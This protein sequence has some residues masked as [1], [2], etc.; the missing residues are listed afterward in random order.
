MP[1]KG[2][3][4]E[5][6]KH[7]RQTIGVA[8]STR[9]RYS[10]YVQHF[11]SETGTD[12]F[13]DKLSHLQPSELIQYVLKQREHHPLPVLKSMITALRSFLQRKVSTSHLS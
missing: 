11:L 1:Q 12:V 5:Y 9:C 2:I 3:I 8:E 6:D 10:R 4:R 7:L 13:Q